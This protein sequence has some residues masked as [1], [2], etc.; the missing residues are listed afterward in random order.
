MLQGVQQRACAATQPEHLSVGSFKVCSSEHTLQRALP[1]PL[2][3]RRRS[4]SARRRLL[5]LLLQHA[6]LRCCSSARC[7]ALRVEGVR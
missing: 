5:P 3:C 4:S 2:P 7:G 1:T 6:L